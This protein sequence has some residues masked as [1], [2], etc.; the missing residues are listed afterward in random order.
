MAA[1]HE[2]G[3]ATL[4]HTPSPMKF[5]NEVLGRP[6]DECACIII[7]TGHPD[8]DARVP[9]IDKKRRW[10]K[11]RDSGSKAAVSGRSHHG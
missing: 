5:L 10:K 9:V 6:A 4:T 2:A 11:S 1:L 8:G 3:L 7:V